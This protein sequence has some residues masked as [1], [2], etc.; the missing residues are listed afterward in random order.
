MYVFAK[1]TYRFNMDL[2]LGIASFNAVIAAA[3]S[4]AAAVPPTGIV[5]GAFQTEVLIEKVSF[6]SLT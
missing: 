5:N 1:L 6:S 2:K 4:A 3:L